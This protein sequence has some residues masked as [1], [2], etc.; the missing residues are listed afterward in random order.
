MELEPTIGN[1]DREFIN[2]WF[3]KLKD[4]SFDLMKDIKVCDKTIAGKKPAIQ[5]IEAKLK[6][7]MERE[8]FSETDKTIKASEEA[9][10][11]LLQ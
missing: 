4:Y 11:R 1:F 9:T 7:S 8:K 6:A 10:K 2:N 3:S 5:N